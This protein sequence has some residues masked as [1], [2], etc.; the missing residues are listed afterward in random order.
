[1]RLPPAPA[2][3]FLH[4]LEALGYIGRNG[5]RFLLRP[6]VLAIG[7]GYLSAINAEVILQPIPQDVVNEVRSS[8]VNG[9]GGGSLV[10]D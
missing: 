1:M 9:G 8:S 5:R 3:R 2:R 6:K 7:T 10:T 4:T